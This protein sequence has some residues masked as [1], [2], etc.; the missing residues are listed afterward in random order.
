[1]KVMWKLIACIQTNPLKQK[2]IIKVFEL[3][4]DNIKEK[5]QENLMTWQLCILLLK[6]VTWIQANNDK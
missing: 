1:M 6:M 2:T 4:M 3:I 5:I